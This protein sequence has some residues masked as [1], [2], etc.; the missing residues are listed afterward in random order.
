MSTMELKNKKEKINDPQIRAE[1]KNFRKIKNQLVSQIK[2][3][4]STTE[5]TLIFTQN[6]FSVLKNESFAVDDADSDKG[7]RI[8][9]DLEELND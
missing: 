5:N 9:F 3:H 7:N 1:L 2:P 8:N 4:K 6:N